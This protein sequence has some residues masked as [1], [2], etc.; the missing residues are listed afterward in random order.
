MFNRGRD[1]DND[2]DRILLD[3]LARLEK[4]EPHEIVS[5]QKQP[6]YTITQ[7]LSG[8]VVVISLIAGF[9]GTWIN[10]SNRLAAQE[11][12]YT[13]T[14]EQ[15]KK[16]LAKTD[17]ETKVVRA[18]IKDTKDSIQ[19]ALNKLTDRIGELDSTVNQLYNSRGK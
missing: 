14:L 3:I 6:S 4:K 9:S 7:V 1:E 12:S 8:A 19:V 18:E 13:M 11:V 15:L 10:F 2:V 16:D 5:E 17:D